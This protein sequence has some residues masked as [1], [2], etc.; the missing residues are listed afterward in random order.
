MSFSKTATFTRNF[1]VEVELAES[2]MRVEQLLQLPPACAAPDSTS[3]ASAN[4]PLVLGKWV[5]VAPDVASAIVTQSAH[6]I[7]QV[8]SVNL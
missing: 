7:A 2:L 8:R 1:N 4:K 5:P 6:K 3:V